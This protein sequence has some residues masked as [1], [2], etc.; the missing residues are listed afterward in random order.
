MA[1]NRPAVIPDQVQPLDDELWSN[2]GRSSELTVLYAVRWSG[3]RE[4]GYLDSHD[5]WEVS[6]IYGGTG[7]LHGDR[8]AGLRRGVVALIPP[9]LAHRE[10]AR[11]RLDTLWLGLRGTRFA[12]LATDRLHLWED[13]DALTALEHVWFA[14]AA[15]RPGCGWEIDALAQ[16]ALARLLRQPEDSLA[17]EAAADALDI[18]VTTLTQHYARPLRVAELA[19]TAGCSEGHF[20]R[21]FRRRTGTT[22]VAFVTAQRMR[23]AMR[24]IT[25]STLPLSAVAK[26][27]GY[28]DPLYFSR[29]F[30]RISGSSPQNYR[31]RSVAE[32][33]ADTC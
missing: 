32:R 4:S 14:A 13:R 8:S 26:A 2:V 12:G 21:A 28:A 23:Q 22:P 1:T 17:H 11:S 6:A 29:V 3:P 31:S 33:S 10:I 25:T 18:A 27:V 5:F 19:A 16:V 9:G 20:F 30:K 7:Q 15:R 24:L